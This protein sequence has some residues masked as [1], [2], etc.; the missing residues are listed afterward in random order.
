MLS[1][2]LV[3]DQPYDA[4]EEPCGDAYA[5]INEHPYRI[6]PQ[7]KTVP[8]ICVRPGA[9]TVDQIIEQIHYPIQDNSQHQR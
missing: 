3:I 7:Q 5:Q 8:V 4:A 6:S 9:G 2:S 1:A